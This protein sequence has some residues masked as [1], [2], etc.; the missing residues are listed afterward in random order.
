MNVNQIDLAPTLSCLMG[1]PFPAASL[2]RPAVELFDEPRPAWPHPPAGGP[3][4][5][6]TGLERNRPA[7]PRAP[8]T[9]AAAE[10]DDQRALDARFS[11]ILAAFT[12]NITRT[13]VPVAL[14][15]L[16]LL[17][18]LAAQMGEL[19]LLA[20][21]LGGDGVAAR[22]G[23]V[24]TAVSASWTLPGLCLCLAVALMPCGLA[25]WRRSRFASPVHRLW[26]VSASAAVV[27][28]LARDYQ[29]RRT[30]LLFGSPGDLWLAGAGAALCLALRALEQ[31][32][33]ASAGDRCST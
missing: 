6:R 30:T 33:R 17:V 14:W 7:S 1:L 28:A 12:R 23:I 3:H 32:V 16:V 9:E 24:P 26:F 15:G 22:G 10:D 21:E 27:L 13:R 19:Q 11:A 25:E 29:G 5:G 2:G 18:F 4:R 31:R 8:A 20:F